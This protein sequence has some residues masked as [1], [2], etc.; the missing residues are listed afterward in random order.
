MCG[1]HLFSCLQTIHTQYSILVKTSTCEDSD[2]FVF[3]QNFR[4]MASFVDMITNHKHVKKIILCFFPDQVPISLNTII[5][6]TK[7][8]ERLK[9]TLLK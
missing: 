9:V 2:V 5:A 6:E 1:R 8:Q 3:Y 4:Q 7:S